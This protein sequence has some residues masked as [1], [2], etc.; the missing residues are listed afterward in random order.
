MIFVLDKF[1]IFFYNVIIY[2]KWRD[3]KNSTL[4]VNGYLEYH[5]N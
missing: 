3:T 5:E 1:D 2:K 4:F